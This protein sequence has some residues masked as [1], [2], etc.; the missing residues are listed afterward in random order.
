MTSSQNRVVH[1]KKEGDKKW[2]HCWASWSHHHQSSSL[3][4][5]Q[6]METISEHSSWRDI[7]KRNLG[8]QI[9]RK[10]VI[11]HTMVSHTSWWYNVITLYTPST[12]RA[13]L[14]SPTAAIWSSHSQFVSCHWSGGHWPGHHPSKD[15][16]SLASYWLVTS[17]SQVLTEI[18]SCSPYTRMEG[19]IRKD[20]CVVK[21][22]INFCSGLLHALTFHLSKPQ[23]LINVRRSQLSST[24]SLCE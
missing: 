4:L 12:V 18:V 9:T 8:W 3:H 2:W 5:T 16:S 6:Y 23:A 14:S 7:Q 13:V 11:F 10:V 15:T 24:N 22:K 17:F 20:Y 19:D 21:N 1:L